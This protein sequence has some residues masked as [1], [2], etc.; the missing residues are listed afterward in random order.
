M[1][2]LLDC[3]LAELA[4]ALRRREV[5]AEDATAA[6]IAGLR[7]TGSRL[8]A[9]VEIEEDSALERARGLDHD[10]AAG[11]ARAGRCTACRWRTRTC[12]IGPGGPACR[13]H[14]FARTMSPA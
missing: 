5:S 9:V 13:E 6:S 11:R 14:G 12:T 3:S 7:D 8:G 10:L 2:A 4:G 1:S